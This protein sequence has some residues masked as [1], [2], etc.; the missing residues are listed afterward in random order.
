[1]SLVLRHEPERIGLTLDRAGWVEVEAL[2]TACRAHG[3]PL[4]RAELEDV[5]A[6]N[7]KK[8][9]AFS[10]DGQRI[11][12]SQGHSVEIE[13]GYTPEV[14][15]A[16]LF[17]GTATRFLDA[18][19]REGLQKQGRHHVHL[20]ADAETAEKVGQRHGK[21]ALLT[22]RSGEMHALGRPFFRSEN[23]VWLTE[24]VPVEFIVF[25]EAPAAGGEGATSHLSD[26]RHER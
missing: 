11:R 7:E 6:N 13:L 1:M 2:L 4:E 22:V 26:D 25:P 3:R 16:E 14:P 17:H 21:V 19:R 5:V 18:I 10:D 12:A 8:R 9:F 24:Q 20:S 15:P 23:G